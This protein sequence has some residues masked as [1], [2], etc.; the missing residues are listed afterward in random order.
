MSLVSDL[1]PPTNSLREIIIIMI[2]YMQNPLSWPSDQ[3]QIKVINNKNHL[4]SICN[5]EL[6]T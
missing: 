6:Q 5:I 4:G 3:Y 2:N 1:G